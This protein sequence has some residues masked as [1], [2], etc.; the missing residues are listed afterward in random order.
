[1]AAGKRESVGG[2][3]R[4]YTVQ[5]GIVNYIEELSLCVLCSGLVERLK[6]VI[7]PYGI[8]SAK[9]TRNVMPALKCMAN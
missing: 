5:L 6:D 2:Q 4:H 7:W 3:V 9:R 1:M 8:L